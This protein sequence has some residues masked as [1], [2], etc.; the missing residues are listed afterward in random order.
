MAIFIRLDGLLTKLGVIPP[1]VD[2]KKGNRGFEK[3][4]YF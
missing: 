3:V 4:R 1:T 2:S